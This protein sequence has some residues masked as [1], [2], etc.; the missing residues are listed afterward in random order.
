[1]I[2]KFRY[3]YLRI[4]QVSATNF[5]RTKNVNESIFYENIFTYN[6]KLDFLQTGLLV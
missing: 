6:V 1:M 3:F 2:P 4:D 5:F